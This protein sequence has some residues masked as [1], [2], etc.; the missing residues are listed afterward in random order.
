MRPS[1]AAEGCSRQYYQSLGPPDL[2]GP[3]EER[4][5]NR[6]GG[7]TQK[8]PVRIHHVN[9]RNPESGPGRHHH[10]PDASAKIAA[11]NGD[12]KLDDD[13]RDGPDVKHAPQGRGDSRPENEQ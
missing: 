6:I 11:I 2:V 5:R 8:R 7:R 3:D 1:I 13:D 9:V 12:E 10:D 4:S